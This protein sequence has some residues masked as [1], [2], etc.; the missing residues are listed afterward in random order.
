MYFTHSIIYI[1][2]VLIFKYFQNQR[3][4]SKGSLFL[5]WL[6]LVVLGVILLKL[7][8]VSGI[9][10]GVGCCTNPKLCSTSAK[11]SFVLLVFG[12]LAVLNPLANILVVVFPNPVLGLFVTLKPRSNCCPMLALPLS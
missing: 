4:S 10:V 12:M 1:K 5:I 9:F 11:G 8:P 6:L 7:N 3:R 2:L